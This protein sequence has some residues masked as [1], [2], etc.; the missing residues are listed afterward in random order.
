MYSHGNHTECKINLNV[1]HF[2][3]FQVKHLQ[4]ISGVRPSAYWLSTLTL[5]SLHCAIIISIVVAL[6]AAFQLDD[7]SGEN[8]A[9]IAVLF[10]R[11]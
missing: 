10:V 6:F 5:D 9:A 1:H 8:L 11:D 7:Y 4:H 3:H 2:H